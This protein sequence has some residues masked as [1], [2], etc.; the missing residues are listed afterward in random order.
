LS[1]SAQQNPYILAELLEQQS[2]AAGLVLF[3]DENPES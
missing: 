3:Y 1:R 2:D